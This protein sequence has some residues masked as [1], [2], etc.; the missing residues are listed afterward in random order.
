MI[1]LTC[2]DT[3]LGGWG[4]INTWTDV[5][6]RVRLYMVTSDLTS[7]VPLQFSHW[8]QVRKVGTAYFFYFLDKIGAPQVRS[9]TEICTK[10]THLMCEQKPCPKW[11]SCRRKISGIMWAYRSLTAHEHLRYRYTTIT[12]VTFSSSLKSYSWHPTTICINSSGWKNSCHVKN[13]EKPNTTPLN[14]KMI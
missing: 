13:K 9:L 10:I 4:V 2:A 1:N 6:A 8:L 14:T 3:G 7:L 5:L 12:P 11:F